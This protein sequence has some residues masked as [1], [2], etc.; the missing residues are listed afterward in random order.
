LTRT[1]YIFYKMATMYITLLAVVCCYFSVHAEYLGHLDN[2]MMT[3]AIQAQKDL[4][5]S[6]GET[7]VLECS[8]DS[9]EYIYWYYPREEGAETDADVLPAGVEISTLES[10]KGFTSTLTLYNIT[11][12]DTGLYECYCG[13]VEAGVHGHIHHRRLTFDEYKAY[14]HVTDG[15]RLFQGKKQEKTLFLSNKVRRDITLPCAVNDPLTAVSLIK[16]GRQL[17]TNSKK[18]MYNSKVGFTI[19][20]LKLTDIGSYK[21]VA[22]NTETGVSEERQFY[23]QVMKSI[24]LIR[25]PV[26]RGVDSVEEGFKA[27]FKCQAVVGKSQATAITWWRKREGDSQLQHIEASSGNRIIIDVPIKSPNM[28]SGN[29][30]MCSFRRHSENVAN[31]QYGDFSMYMKL[32]GRLRISDVNVAEDAAEYYC[33]VWSEGTE[34]MSEALRLHVTPQ[35]ISPD[36]ASPTQEAEVVES[37]TYTNTEETGDGPV[38]VVGP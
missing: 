32:T 21:C 38:V 4:T 22:T 29:R 11:S 23:V 13:A 27:L 26:I 15:E 14:V 2:T 36:N 35:S 20:A 30:T 24:T 7:I 10:D 5:K 19:T 18:Y 16:W 3:H 1:T 28:C 6:A 33:K 34:L 9:D 8:S 37:I 31:N 17:P 12:E 25:P